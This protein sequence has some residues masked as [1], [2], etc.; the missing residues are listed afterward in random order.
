MGDY[1]HEKARR[2]SWDTVS[3]QVMQVYEEAREAARFASR[4]QET[5]Q[6]TKQETKQQESHVHNAV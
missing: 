6:E 1:G 4:V 3:T 5:R 2:Y